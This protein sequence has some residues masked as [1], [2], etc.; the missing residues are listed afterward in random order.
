MAR[1]RI[2]IRRSNMQRLCRG[3]GSSVLIT[4][5]VLVLLGA[6]DAKTAD[7]QI[8]FVNLFRNLPNVQTGN[9]N[10]LG[11]SGAF[12]SG[13][14]FSVG[15]GDF[16][17]GTLT[18]PGPGSPVPLTLTS[19]TTLLFQTPTLASQAAMD[20]AF[21]FGTYQFDATGGTMGPATAT[22]G[23][24]ADFYPQSLPFLDGTNFSD[25][26]GM[27]AAAPF[28]FDFSP[29]IT[30]GGVSESFI[31]FTLFD[32]NTSS[33]V[34]NSGFLPASTTGL[35]LPANTLQAGHAYSYEL[36]FSNRLLVPD[37]GAVFLGQ[38]GFDSRTTGRFSTTAVPEPGIAIIGLGLV[39]S[40]A[41]I[42]RRRRA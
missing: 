20:A 6:A 1:S 11:A 22:I 14:L 17:A 4:A 3:S 8:S 38:L 23:Y 34:F 42:L 21:P 39:V 40:S 10:S 37:P 30:G 7:A 27:N 15:A 5:V 32:V 25:L 35:V 28:A 31:F 19:P 41:A 29:F 24:T 36:D 33:F 9:G 13:T 18:Y 16:A 2:R 12:F 26:Q